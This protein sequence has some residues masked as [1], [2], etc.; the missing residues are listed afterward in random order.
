MIRETTFFSEL[1]EPERAYG[2]VE[3]YAEGEINGEIKGE[4]KTLRRLLERKFGPLTPDLALSLQKLRS[5]ELEALT[6][7]VLDLQ[8]LEELRLG[9]Q[10]FYNGSSGRSATH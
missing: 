2:H 4:L 9:L 7:T 3:G 10:N 6:V 1:L 8:S 5:N